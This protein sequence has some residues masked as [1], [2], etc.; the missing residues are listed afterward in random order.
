MIR[1]LVTATYPTI[2]ETYTLVLRRLGAA[3]AHAWVQELLD[4]VVAINPEPFAKLS[5]PVWTYDRHFDLI[6]APRWS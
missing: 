5:Q 6:P 3:Y 4:S 2:S 1:C